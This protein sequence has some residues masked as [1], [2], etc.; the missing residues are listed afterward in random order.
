MFGTVVTYVRPDGS[1]G[2]VL[3]GGP[4]V[5]DAKQQIIKDITYFLT[6]AQTK[7]YQIVSFSIQWQCEGCYGS[8][9]VS[10][11]RGLLK[12]KKCP[13]CGGKNS[14]KDIV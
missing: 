12:T 4:T 2:T 11:G 7:G 5:E 9:K 3:S 1:V 13:T 14:T 8:G 6:D 10:S